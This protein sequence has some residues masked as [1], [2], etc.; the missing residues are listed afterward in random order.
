MKNNNMWVWVAVIAALVAAVT[1]V[2]VLVLR[3][4]KKASELC[5]PIFDC[6][7]C[8]EPECD[9]ECEC[10]CCAEEPAAEVTE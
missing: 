7:C 10:D 4:Q 9:C 8:D 3:A 1:T 2:A 6:G 5:E